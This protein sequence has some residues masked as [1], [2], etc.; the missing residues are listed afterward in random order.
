[1]CVALDIITSPYITI[2]TAAKSKAKSMRRRRRLL[3]AENKAKVSSPNI[4]PEGGGGKSIAPQ[5]FRAIRYQFLFF[6]PL[7][8]YSCIAHD[9]IF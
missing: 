4:A 2:A 3:S 9:N 5:P 8:N 7:L 6:L 1:M